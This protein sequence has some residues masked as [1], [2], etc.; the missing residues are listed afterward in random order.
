MKAEEILKKYESF[1]Y[2]EGEC[3]ETHYYKDNVILAME[4]YAQ[5]Q[6]KNNVSLDVVSKLICLDC[7]CNK[8]QDDANDN[9][10]C[11]NIMCDWKGKLFI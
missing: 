4:E 9:Y 10:T 1:H 6:V 8:M 5:Q 11:L 7:G 3:D 2:S